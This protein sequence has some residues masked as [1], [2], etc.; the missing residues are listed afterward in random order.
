LASQLLCVAQPTN[1]HD[2]PLKLVQDEK[3]LSVMM[4]TPAHTSIG[5]E[6]MR[7]AGGM[8][9]VQK[10]RDNSL[11]RDVGDAG[12]CLSPCCADSSRNRSHDDY[13]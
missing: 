2:V 3:S 8:D 12:Y 6:P 13:H 10:D 7:L 11:G 4:V 5:Y 9:H 1:A